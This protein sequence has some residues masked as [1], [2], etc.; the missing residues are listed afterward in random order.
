MPT[1]TSF[2]GAYKLAKC[3]SVSGMVTTGTRKQSASWPG[4]RH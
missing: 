1:G 4:I 3:R 2:P